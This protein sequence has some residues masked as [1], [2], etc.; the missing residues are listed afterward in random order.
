VSLGRFIEHASIH[1]TELSYDENAEAMMKTFVNLPAEVITQ[2]V[3]RIHEE[4]SKCF[5]ANIL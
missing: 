4:F 5:R 1:G 2:A 3:S